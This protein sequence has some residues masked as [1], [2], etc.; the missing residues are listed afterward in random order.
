[1][2]WMWQH[3]PVLPACGR[4]RQEDQELEARLS[5]I[6]RSSLKNKIKV[7]GWIRRRMNPSFFF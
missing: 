3:I 5:C 1:M 6:V 4:L 7:S 2:N